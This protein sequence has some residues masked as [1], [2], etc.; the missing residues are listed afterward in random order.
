MLILDKNIVYNILENMAIINI[1]ENSELLYQVIA[2]SIRI[3]K[4]RHYFQFTT[5]EMRDI[6][7]LNNGFIAPEV[8]Q[9]TIHNYKIPMD[10]IKPWKL[11]E[12]TN[13]PDILN[14]LMNDIETKT[15]IYQNYYSVH[16]LPDS[17][18]EKIVSD[19]VKIYHNNPN[20]WRAYHGC[21]GDLHNQLKEVIIEEIQDYYLQQPKLSKLRI[22]VYQNTLYYF[23]KN[24]TV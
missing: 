22:Q 19:T 23:C 13:L 17:I 14:Q 16:D 9:T 1:K 4:E 2:D 8:L 10:L 21:K 20:Y 6:T 24:E 11:S 5:Y 3:E 15:S 7:L 18:S 12:P